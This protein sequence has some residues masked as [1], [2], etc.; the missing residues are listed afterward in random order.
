[1]TPLL[2]DID[3]VHASSHPP[4]AHPNVA[5]LFREQSPG[6]DGDLVQAPLLFPALPTLGQPEQLQY[7]STHPTQV[8]LLYAMREHHPQHR[9]QYR[10][11]K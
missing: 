10:L 5:L 7:Q 9:M 1:M 11:Q 3:H 2:A 4:I 8:P 6:T